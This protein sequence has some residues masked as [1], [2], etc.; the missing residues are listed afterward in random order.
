MRTKKISK[1]E[2]VISLFKEGY[3]PK[4]ITHKVDRISFKGVMDCLFIQAGEGNIRRSD[5]WFS[6]NHNIRDAM[7]KYFMARDRDKNV[8]EDESMKLLELAE[9]SLAHPEEFKLYEKLRSARV[10][11]GDMYELI[12]EIELLLHRAIK[13]TLIKKYGPGELEWW[14]K[15]VPQLVRSKCAKLY[16]EDDDP[17]REP[18]CYTTFIDFKNIFEKQW[19]EFEKVLPKHIL[20]FKKEFFRNLVTINKVRNRVMHPIKG[21]DFTP[22]DFAFVHEFNATL[23]INNWQDKEIAICL[24]AEL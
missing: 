7:E 4:D 21:Y 1:R 16:E 11:H 14:R 13:S 15:G 12:S 23:N 24:E 3:S 6:I 9:I 18:Y 20:R 17:A 2:E 10:A 22:E 19:G 8:G 5:I